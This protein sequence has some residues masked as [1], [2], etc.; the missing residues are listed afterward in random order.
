[1]PEEWPQCLRHRENELAVRK[2]KKHLVGEMLGEKKCTLLAARR[3]QVEA[4][5][6]EWSE[7]VM[8]AVWVRTPDS[9]YT[10]QIV[11]AIAG[12]TSNVLDPFGAE[13]AVLI[14]LK[15]IRYE[16]FKG[17]ALFHTTYTEYFKQNLHMFDALDFLAELT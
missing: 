14:S 10:L 9:G 6:A 11:P 7:I 16:P 2:I 5:A 4:L 13:A 17:R 12:S 15:K 8:P 1:M 3:A